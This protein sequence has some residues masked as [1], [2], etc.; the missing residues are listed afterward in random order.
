[1]EAASFGNGAEFGM[2]SIAVF[3]GFY[4]PE[5]LGDFHY[6]RLTESDWRRIYWGLGCYGFHI[7]VWVYGL[8]LK[9]RKLGR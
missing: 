4:E 3:R 9:R 2:A 7:V 8:C 1:M 6:F 5:M